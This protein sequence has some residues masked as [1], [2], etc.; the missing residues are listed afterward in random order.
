[1]PFTI[2]N[3]SNQC[4][5][6]NKN[7]LTYLLFVLTSL[8]VLSACS[9]DNSAELEKLSSQMATVVVLSIEN[10]NNDA[11]KAAV[12]PLPTYTPVPTLEPL[13]TYTPLPTPEPLATYT[14]VPTFIPLSTLE[15][16]PTYTPLPTLEALPTYA[17][18]PTY[19][20]LPT[21][22]PIPTVAPII[23]I[24][25][26]T[27]SPTPTATPT[28]LGYEL[29]HQIPNMTAGANSTLSG[30][31]DRTL[32]NIGDVHIY[33]FE[34]LSGQTVVVTMISQQVDTLLELTNPAGVM[35]LRVDDPGSSGTNASITRKLTSSGLW[36]IEARSATT[37]QGDLGAYTIN[38]SLSMVS[39]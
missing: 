19:V 18:L 16:L 22:T 34:G 35:E 3:W 2:Y 29:I 6:V 9:Q 11:A 37:G 17:P 27:P 21:Y 4:F 33:K 39:N 36:T 31:F 5:M 8:F 38:F 26:P 30:V 32:E 13:P 24:A 23:I 10:K 1:M 28:P 7:S 15:P 25:T 14:P 20:P 12:K